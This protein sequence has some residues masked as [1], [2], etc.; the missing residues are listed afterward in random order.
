MIENIFYD[1]NNI[2]ENQSKDK[3]NLWPKMLKIYVVLVFFINLSYIQL[4]I[5][6][7][8]AYHDLFAD[9]F[10]FISYFSIF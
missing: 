8:Y 3:K 4:M 7:L 9:I 5:T 2:V 1:N 6:I 10:Q